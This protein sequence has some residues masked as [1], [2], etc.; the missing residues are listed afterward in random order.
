VSDPNPVNEQRLATLHPTFA[1]KVR[2]VL[3]GL[4]AANYQP[5]IASAYRSPEDQLKLYK[6]GRSTVRFSFHCAQEKGQPA[7]LA[8]DIVDK[9]LL[10]TVPQAH[11]FWRILGRLAKAQGL[12]WGGD[13]KSFPDLAHLQALPNEKLAAVR[14]ATQKRRPLPL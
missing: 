6:L 2:K 12:V 8:A 14:T 5:L 11:P 4:R 3:E 7:A 1:A 13:W 9:R 10:W